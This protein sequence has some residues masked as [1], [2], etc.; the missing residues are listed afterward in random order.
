MRTIAESN[1]DRL[2]W[3]CSRHLLW[4]AFIGVVF[5]IATTPTLSEAFLGLFWISFPKAF[6]RTT[7]ILCG[8]F[9][10]LPGIFARHLLG[11]LW[12]W[13]RYLLSKICP[14]YACDTV[15]FQELQLWWWWWWCCSTYNFDTKHSWWWWFLYQGS[16]MGGD[17]SLMPFPEQ[18]ADSTKRNNWTEISN[19]PTALLIIMMTRVANTMMMMMAKMM[20]MTM[21]LSFH[22]VHSGR[23]QREREGGTEQNSE[24]EGAQP[25]GTQV[26][27][28]SATRSGSE[29][30][31]S[32]W[33]P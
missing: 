1:E 8:V 18:D 27:P 14:I 4:A 33:G 2:L 13:M 23:G 32:L 19:I 21:L 5:G 28:Q 15:F 11:L 30:T 6:D 22:W 7:F 17:C 3:I 20:M 25:P 31:R 12:I 26:D 10:M 16:N 9:A 29:G 24:Q